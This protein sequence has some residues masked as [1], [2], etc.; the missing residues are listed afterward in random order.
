LIKLPSNNNKMIYFLKKLF[1]IKELPRGS[2]EIEWVHFFQ[3][4]N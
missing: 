2:P 3:I 1:T 4:I